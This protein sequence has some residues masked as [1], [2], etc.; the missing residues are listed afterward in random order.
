MDEAGEVIGSDG[1]TLSDKLALYEASRAEITA[2]NI[3]E[4]DKEDEKGI[5]AAPSDV[6]GPPE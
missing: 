2:L 4:K 6:C 5:D 1:T 3:S